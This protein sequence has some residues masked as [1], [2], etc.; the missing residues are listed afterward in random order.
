MGVVNEV[1]MGLLV[2]ADFKLLTKQCLRVFHN[3]FLCWSDPS[4]GPIAGS[5][6]KTGFIL[7]FE[8]SLVPL[9]DPSILPGLA[10]FDGPS[11]EPD[12][13][14]SNASSNVPSLVPTI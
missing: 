5:P 11:D 7:S 14:P 4:E 6:G 2:E 8:P 9:E 10:P 1:S 12:N 3:L 13:E